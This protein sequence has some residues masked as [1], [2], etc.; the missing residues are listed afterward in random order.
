MVRHAAT[1]L[2]TPVLASSASFCPPDGAAIAVVTLRDI[3]P[4]RAL[5]REKEA[6]LASAAH[7]LRNPLAA[8]LGI[9]QVLQLRI[10]HMGRVPIR[11]SSTSC[12]PSSW[13]PGA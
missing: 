8:V 13:P 6:F 11:G 3:A 1:G 5:E 10:E 7:D 4:L 12:G 2:E 9:S